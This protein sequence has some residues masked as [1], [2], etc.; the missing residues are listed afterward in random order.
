MA[1]FPSVEASDLQV[2]HNIPSPLQFTQLYSGF[3]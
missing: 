1:E 3:R 2:L